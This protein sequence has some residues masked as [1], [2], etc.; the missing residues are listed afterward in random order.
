[1]SKPLRIAL[2]MQGGTAWMGGA[3][4]IKNIIL[5]LASLPA[6]VRST[7]EICLLC[8][9]TIDPNILSQVE[10]Y[11]A[12]VF[13][14]ESPTLFSRL[15]QIVRR[16]LFNEYYI[17]IS[18]FLNTC[19]DHRIDFI[20]PYFTTKFK[21]GQPASAAWIPDFQ[22]KY[23]P[24]LFTFTN[25]VARN[26]E[27]ENTAKYAST[28][29]VSSNSAEKDLQTFLPDCKG[30]VRVLPFATM[31]SVDSPDPEQLKHI[32]DRYNLPERFFLI[33]NQFWQHKNHLTVFQ[34][35][36][37][38]QQQDIYPVVVCTG[39]LYDSRSKGYIKKVMKTINDLGISKQVHLTGLIPKKDQM[40]LMI[41]SLAIIQPSLFEGWS[42]IVEESKCL[43]K[44]IILSDIPVHLEQNPLRGRFFKKDSPKELSEVIAE[45]WGET[46]NTSNSEWYHTLKQDNHQILQ[47]FG[48][49]FMRIVQNSG[50]R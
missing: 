47:E 18:K 35:M 4:Y 21:K 28:I 12:E 38:L 3:E 17:Y 25:I 2:I 45:C 27:L 32:L 16:E 20:Y 43:D 22:H 19:P 11:L 37:L 5:A 48:S 7:F 33:S 44:K 15:T 13:Y 29:V 36:K 23:L 31:P 14:L 40:Q 42:T 30:K 50:D 6:E 9:K 46:Q 8:D 49:N 41:H 39:N 1:M 24:Q 26:K 34:A 10:P